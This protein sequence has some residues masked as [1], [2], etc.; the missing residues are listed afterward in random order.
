VKQVDRHFDL[1]L[2]RFSQGFGSMR[3][4]FVLAFRLSL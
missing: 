3:M 4:D 2:A 1:L